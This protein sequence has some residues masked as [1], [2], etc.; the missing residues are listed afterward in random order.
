M[1]GRYTYLFTWKQLHRL[2]RLSDVPPEDLTP[3]YNVAPTQLVPAVRQDAS[4]GRHGV[5]LRWGLIPSWATDPSIGGRMINARGESVAEKPAFRTALSRRRCLVPVSGFYEWQVIPGQKAK[6][7]WWI[8]RTDRE[9]FAIAGLWERWTKG[10]EPLE[11]F[12]LITTTP[13]DLMAPLHDRMLVIV[14][15]QDYD[16]WL[17]PAITDSAAVTPL[18][19]PAPVDGLE[20]YPISTRVNSPR[21]DDP[22]LIEPADASR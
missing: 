7:P 22:S 14:A 19:R 4:G 11:T 18:L 20:A 16:L 1:C 6:Q 9:P 8:G 13:N 3:R 21:F 15:P 17:D 5:I 10:P 2:M 12:T